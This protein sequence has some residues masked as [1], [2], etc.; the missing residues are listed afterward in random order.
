MVY[1]HALY[2][3]QE[4]PFCLWPRGTYSGQGEWSELWWA[5][6]LHKST[7]TNVAIETRLLLMIFKFSGPS[8]PGNSVISF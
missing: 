1:R 7:H 6:V 8:G 4:D 3:R 5:T 2:T